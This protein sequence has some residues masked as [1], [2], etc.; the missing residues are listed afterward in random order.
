MAYSSIKI[1]VEKSQNGLQFIEK[2]M[3][4]LCAWIDTNIAELISLA[5]LLTQSGKDRKTLLAS[6]AIQK[7][8]TPMTWIRQTR[9]SQKSIRPGTPTRLAES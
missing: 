2:K 9:Q 3:H 7:L 5:D 6:F 1:E 8:T 4:I